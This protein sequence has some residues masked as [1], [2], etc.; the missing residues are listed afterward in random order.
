M[1]VQQGL[2]IGPMMNEI[3][4]G[5]PGVVRVL[6]EVPPIRFPNWLVTHRALRTSRR[7]RLVFDALVETLD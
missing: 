6:D 7:I 5:T 4:S 2:G 3:A 1:L